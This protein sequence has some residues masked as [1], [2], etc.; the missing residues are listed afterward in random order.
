MFEQLQK[1]ILN[2]EMEASKADKKYG[3]V[4]QADGD[5]GFVENSQKLRGLSK[6]MQPVGHRKI[7]SGLSFKQYMKESRDEKARKFLER[8]QQKPS[9]SNLDDP[10]PKTCYNF[11][12][13]PRKKDLKTMVKYVLNTENLSPTKRKA[14]VRRRMNLTYSEERSFNGPMPPRRIRK[15]KLKPMNKH[16]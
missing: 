7:F 16:E 13:D 4:A 15:R 1:L 11:T 3:V 5:M 9:Q 12:P 10:M 6:L 14:K 8:S 2:K